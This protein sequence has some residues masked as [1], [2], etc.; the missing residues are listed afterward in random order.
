[1]RTRRSLRGLVGLAALV[2]LAVP[3]PASATGTLDQSQ[4]TFRGGWVSFSGTREFAQTFTAG[5][6]GNLDQVDLFLRSRAA[7]ESGVFGDLTVQIETAVGGIPSGVVL[8]SATVP[9]ASV[10]TTFGWV[11]VPLSQPAPSSAGTQYAIVLSAPTSS[12]LDQALDPGLCYD[13]GVGVGNPYAAGAGFFSL[14][15]GATWTQN[16]DGDFMFKTFVTVSCDQTGNQA[17]ELNCVEEG[18]L[19]DGEHD[20]GQQ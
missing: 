10:P 7:F 9:A 6:S 18:Q 15:A 17:G 14:D 8:A 11:S 1:M 4:T 12:C 3:A 5:I 2:L 20:N 16:G 19:G 13:W